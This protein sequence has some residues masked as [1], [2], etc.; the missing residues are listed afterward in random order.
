QALVQ[1]NKAL[2]RSL[3]DNKEEYNGL[4]TVIDKRNQ[5]IDKEKAKLAELIRTK[6]K[7]DSATADQRL[8]IQKLEAAQAVAI[9]RYKKLDRAIGNSSDRMIRFQDNL[10]RARKSL[11]STA[12]KVSAAG[13][14]ISSFFGGAALAV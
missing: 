11:Q 10:S 5:L 2:G 7:D 1:K 14:S 4:K 12:D 9:D 13:Q 8:A 3:A 6:G